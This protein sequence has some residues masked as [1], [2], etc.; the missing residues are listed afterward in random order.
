MIKCK[1]P[2]LKAVAAFYAHEL[3]I[4][5]YFNLK[6]K[7]V[8]NLS[9]YGSCQK[10]VDEP[11]FIIKISKNSDQFVTLAHEMVHVKQYL[12]GELI[13]N[14]TST[15]FKGVEYSLELPYYE[16]P[17]EWEALGRMQGLYEEWIK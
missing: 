12:A 11:T 5:D 3:G 6:I 14:P 13:D 2:V 15:T 4:T 17:W 8:K 10:I 9:H 7:V 16:S 1:D